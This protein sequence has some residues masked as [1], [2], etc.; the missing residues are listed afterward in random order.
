MPEKSGIFH[1]SS[2][3]YLHLY[4]LLSKKSRMLF[5][6]AMNMGLP[7][8]L[9]FPWWKDLEWDIPGVGGD[10]LDMM[11]SYRNDVIMFKMQP[12]G[13]AR[14][15][16][17]FKVNLLFTF[18]CNLTLCEPD[19]QVSGGRAW[20]SLT[21]CL[22]MEMVAEPVSTLSSEFTPWSEGGC[23]IHCNWWSS[24]TL[25]SCK[26]QKALHL[27]SRPCASAYQ[28]ENHLNFWGEVVE[29][30]P[31]VIAVRGRAFPHQ[32][33]GQCQGRAQKSGDPPPLWRLVSVYGHSI[34]GMSEAVVL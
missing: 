15:Q 5:C 6:S 23:W 34:S 21:Q 26:I 13:S 19:L 32:P 30:R 4:I 20:R 7:G 31:I 27:I 10:V 29:Q 1:S 16:K 25:P 3:R 28:L 17:P 33:A 24:F 12:H 11:K 18:F 8:D 2:D 9:F 14:L 22:P